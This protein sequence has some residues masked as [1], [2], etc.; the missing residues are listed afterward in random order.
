MNARTPPLLTAWVLGNTVCVAAG[1]LLSALGHLNGLGYLLALVPA[2]A[3][4]FWSGK[5]SGAFA[6][7][8]SRRAWRRRLRRPLP[9]VFALLALLSLLGGLLHAPSNYDALTYRLPRVLHWLAEGE[10]HWITTPNLR[11]NLSATNSEWLMAPWLAWFRSDRALFLLNWI[12]YLFLPGLIFSVFRLAGV[13]GRVAWPWMWLL[14]AGYGYVLQAGSIGNDLVGAVF[15]L[16]AV[17]YALL[18]QRTGNPLALFLAVLS[19]ALLSGTK[20]TNLPLLLPVGLALLPALPLCRKRP[21]VVAS[22]CVVAVAVSFLPTAFLNQRHAGH[23]SGDREDEF[24]VQ[25]ANPVVAL[26]GNVLQVAFR[27]FEPPVLPGARRFDVVLQRVPTP[28]AA[29]WIRRGFP[30]FTLRPGELPQEESSALG[31]CVS[32]LLLLS[33]G[34]ALRHLGRLRCVMATPGF[35]IGTGAWLALV[36]FLA[37]VAVE[38]TPRLLLPY[39]TLLPLP[40]LLLAPHG[41]LVRRGWWRWCATAAAA[42]ALI[43]LVLTPARPLWPVLTLTATKEGG[44]ASRLRTVYATYAARNDALAPLRRHLPQS[45]RTIGYVGGEDDMEYSLWRPFGRRSVEHLFDGR[46]LDPQTRPPMEWVVIKQ[47]VWERHAGMPFEQW[48][49]THGGKLVGSRLWRAELQRP[50]LASPPPR[51]YHLAVSRHSA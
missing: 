9:L 13:P 51:R 12:S 22:V 3:V 18:V 25:A 45:G 15:V 10:W 33:G 42:S 31:L 35:W 44:P 5:Q 47:E 4:L 27:N 8:P 1:W 36:V 24:R 40:L 46:Q 38:A 7:F 28:E 14:P 49:T 41:G 19:A 29:E 32:A 16:A 39:Y 50:V 21:L 23:W 48:L 34:F 6:H 30:R 37:K 20:V 11:M 17:H 26:A 43:G 2:G